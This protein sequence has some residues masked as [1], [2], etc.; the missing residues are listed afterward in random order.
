MNNKKKTKNLKAQTASSVFDGVNDYN[1]VFDGFGSASSN[2]S[3]GDNFTTSASLSSGLSGLNNLAQTGARQNQAFINRDPRQQLQD[4]A[5]GD[6]RFY[7]LQSELNSRM[8]DQE[9]GS[10][11]VAESQRGLGNS[12]FAGA[13]QGQLLGDATLRDLTTR[14]ESLGFQNNQA[15]QNLGASQG[16]IQGLASLLSQ[17][18]QLAQQS[19]L[20]G[21]GNR[22]QIAMFNAQQRQNTDQFNA[23]QALSQSGKPSIWGQALSALGGIAGSLVAPGVGTAIGGS[24]GGLLGGAFG[25]KGGGGVP[26]SSGGAGI[27]NLSASPLPSGF[28]NYTA[29]NNFNGYLGSTYGFDPNSAFTKSFIQ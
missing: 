3:K 22:D 7:N 5:S 29:Q 2:L 13:R 21:L 14:N 16:V 10:L 18:A 11:Q 1:A 23:Q 6:N 4:L 9:L 8:L 19:G 17:P 27:P 15:V 28:T 12:T 20:T 25:G 24:L 26:L